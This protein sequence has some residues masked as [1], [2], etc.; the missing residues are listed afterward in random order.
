LRTALAAKGYPTTGNSADV[1]SADADE[2]R[3]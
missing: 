3:R 2:A 1:V